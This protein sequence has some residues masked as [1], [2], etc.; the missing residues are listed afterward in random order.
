MAAWRSP[1][2][3]G[4]MFAANQLGYDAFHKLNRNCETQGTVEF[5]KPVAD[6][7]D[8]DQPTGRIEQRASRIAGEYGCVGLNDAADDCTVFGRHL[9]PQ[10]ADHAGCQRLVKPERT[11]D[12]IGE[13]TYAQ[14]LGAADR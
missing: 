7:I 5:R 3:L 9:P 13:L 10:C 6:G 8:A 1:L 14:I 4:H 11:S 2:T 12:R